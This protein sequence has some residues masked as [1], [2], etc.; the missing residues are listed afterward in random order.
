MK[1]VWK[2]IKGYEDLYQV[3]NLGRIKTI[4]TN[5]IRKN[6]IDRNGYER[7]MIRNKL[8]YV[9]RLVAEVFIPNPKQY[10]EVNHKDENKLNNTV[11]NLEWCSREYNNSYGN[12]DNKVREKLKIKIEQ[13]DLQGNHIKTW[14]SII[15]A[16]KF[17]NNYHIT[18]CLKG[19]RKTAGGY[20]WKY[21]ETRKRIEE[22]LEL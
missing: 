18:D 13:Y 4:K 16:I 21:A 8:L 15:S 12:R 14:Q 3:S 10:R 2:N 1:E 5:R 19:R 9:H 7:I 20:I 22:E 6:Q 17:Y 11:D